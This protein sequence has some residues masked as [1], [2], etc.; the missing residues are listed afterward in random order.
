MPRLRP[1]FPAESGLWG[2]PTLINNVETLALVPW[3]V[4][5]GAEKFAAIGTA[6][7]KGT[8]VFA[9]AGKI[10]RG[11]LIEVPMG[12][13]MREIVE[14]I[15]GG[16]PEGRRIKAVQIGGPSGGCVPASLM[17]TPVD[18]ESLREAGAIM[19]SGGM[20]VLD[21]SACMVDIARYFLQFTQD[22]SCGKCTFCRVGT[23]RMLDILDKLCAGKAQR[24]HL[25]ELERSPTRSAPAACAG[26]AKPR[27]IPCSR[28][29]VI[30]ATNTRPI[31]KAAARR[32]MRRACQVSGHRR[33][34]RLHSL[35]PALPGQSHPDD[36]LRAPRNQPGPLHPLRH[37]PQSLPAKRHRGHMST[38]AITIDG[39]QVEV[40]PGQTVLRPRGRSASTFQL[41]ATWKSAAR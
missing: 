34:H 37:L 17:D 8:K 29:C 14:E 12:T 35:R 7:S 23:K 36:A 31:C 25:D 27:R 2:K 41:F 3:I 30:S 19:G 5:H 38:F 28:R 39:K 15:G 16:A 22:Q 20:V 9:L 33:L 11:G 4:R 40:A 18:Y 13:T 10:R 32:A 24:A 6:K 21:D 26:W 1:P